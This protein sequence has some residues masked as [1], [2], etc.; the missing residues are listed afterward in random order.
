MTVTYIE[1]GIL[2]RDMLIEAN[3]RYSVPADN[4]RRLIDFTTKLH[5][6]L[7]SEVPGARFYYKVNPDN[8]IQFIWGRSVYGGDISISVDSSSIYWRAGDNYHK[9]DSIQEMVTRM[10][11][12]VESTRMDLEV[13]NYCKG[14]WF[15]DEDG[16]HCG[17]GRPLAVD[18]IDHTPWY[19]V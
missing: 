2:R 12:Y 6:L 5:T 10:R 19:I 3:N 18:C 13:H 11:E 9:V 15:S 17:M 16:Q 8:H 14:C 1:L 4:L 7:R